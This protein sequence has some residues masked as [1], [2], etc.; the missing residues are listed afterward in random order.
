MQ[1]IP[2]EEVFSFTGENRNELSLK[3]ENISKKFTE[4]EVLAFTNHVA[5]KFFEIYNRYPNLKVTTCPH[6]ETNEFQMTISTLQN[7]SKAVKEIGLSI[8]NEFNKE[9]K[10]EVEPR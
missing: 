5:M 3:E 2:R 10:T 7:F 8:L 4:A 9:N 6:P 1:F